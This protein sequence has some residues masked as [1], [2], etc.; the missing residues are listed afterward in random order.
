MREKLYFLPFDKCAI[1]AILL[2][3]FTSL[4]LY[5]L[6]FCSAGTWQLERQPAVDANALTAQAKVQDPQ[7]LSRCNT[8]SNEH[9]RQAVTTEESRQTESK[10]RTDKEPQSRPIQLIRISQ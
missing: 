8:A 1:A 2:F 9:R 3:F 10:R 5:F 7:L 4:H 6:L